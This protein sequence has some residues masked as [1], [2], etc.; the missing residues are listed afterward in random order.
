VTDRFPDLKPEPQPPTFRAD[1]PGRR[2]GL[3]KRARLLIVAAVAFVLLLVLGAAWVRLAYLSDLPPT[4]SADALWSLNRAPGVTFLDRNGVR[5]ASRGPRNGLRVRLAEL[6]AYVPRAFLAAE[7]RR[8]YQHGPVDWI[9]AARA[10]F[11]NAK[12]GQVVQGGSTLTQQ[13]ARSLF[14]SPDQTM[15]RK[16]QEAALAFRL[17]RMMSRDQ[18]LELYL[19]RVFFGASAYGVEAA[20]QTYFGKPAATLTL[21]EAAL[22]AAL[23]KAPSRLSP[24]NDMAAA[25]A[26]SRLVLRQMREQGWITDA[27]ERRALA[28][29]PRLA[30]EPPEDDDFGYVLDLAQAQAARLARGRAPDLVVQ[31]TI[32]P[33]LQTSASQIVRR[34]MQTDGQHARAGQAALVALGPDGAIRALVGGLDH[35]FSR[36]DRAVQA[37]RQPGSA[38][39]PFVYAAAL[40]AGVKPGDIR[41][42]KPVQLGPWSPTNYGGG[43]R[44]AV[45]VQDAL[46]HSINTVSVRLTQEVG[47]EKVAELAARFGLYSIPARPGL[48]VALGAYETNLLDLTSGYQ[49]F[50]QAGVRRPA[51]LISRITTSAGE[52]LYT[53]PYGAALQVFDPARDGDMVR[54]LKGVVE[55]GTGSRAAFGRPAAGKTGTSQTW[56]DAWFIGFTPDWVCGVWVG[57]DDDQP[58]N[59]V[60]GADLPAEIWRRFMLVAH[61][62][63]PPRDFPWLGG[64]AG[65]AGAPNAP[66]AG[67]RGGF[68]QGLSAAFARTAAGSDDPADPAGADQ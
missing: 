7:D 17:G 68:Y 4:P 24:V 47:A 9:G 2:R 32:D 33:G 57:N 16:V 42:D 43:Y 3:S 63:L 55:R 12:A 30:A 5:I 41:S 13:L 45:T 22:L 51:I 53:A 25:L 21:S 59:K 38:F 40:E 14:L 66:G 26:R 18:I 23:P 8:F 39:K 34:V 28:S 52:V 29:P 46:A 44:G 6:P 36:F 20:S 64:S 49:V 35:R 37:E 61:Q 62:G 67:E 1:L 31:L 50:Q 15:K 27:D 60:T 48:S 11:A 56:R 58:M 10:A 54:M 19:N 65:T